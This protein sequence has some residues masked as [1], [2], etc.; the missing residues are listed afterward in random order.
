VNSC[1][2]EGRVR[3]RRFAPVENAF[4]YPLFLMY[5][6]LAELPQ[7]FNAHPL[8]SA[9]GPN[10]A[11]F[12]RRDHLGDPDR[13]LDACVR[14]RAA[15]ETGQRPTGPIRLLTHLSYFG[16]RFNPVSFYYCFDAADEVVEVVVAEVNNTPWNEQHV[17]VL[18]EAMNEG[19]ADKKRY[20]FQKAFHV[21]PF[22]GM[23]QVCDWR[24]TR[25]GEA[26]VVHME[27]FEQG[28]RLF[29]ATMALHRKA[30]TRQALTRVLIR[31]PLMTA[32]VVG[33][34]YWQA[35]RLWWKRAPFYPHPK[36]KRVTSGERV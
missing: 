34:I 15:Q 32:Q 1:I 33:A 24:F 3:H 10:V 12:R 26:L 6:D 20:R 17:Y 7:V 16:Y 18:S 11:C 25:P 4:E 23:D 8:W 27:N 36:H 31:Y 5:L 22:M 9:D 29:D 35:L 30:L 2:Y 28:A 14:D 13:S 19:S 21:S